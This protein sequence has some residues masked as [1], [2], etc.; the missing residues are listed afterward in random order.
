[1]TPFGGLFTAVAHPVPD[2]PALGTRVPAM[3]VW[4]LLV[5]CGYGS[6]RR[7]SCVSAAIACAVW[8]SGCVTFRLS[9]LRPFVTL[10]HTMT[11]FTLCIGMHM[12]GYALR[13]VRVAPPL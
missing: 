6:W 10:L 13:V 12:S 3:A 11:A 8:V 4:I 7:A 2:R 9:R 5:M 1:M